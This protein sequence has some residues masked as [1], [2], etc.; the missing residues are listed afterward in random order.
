MQ[1]LGERRMPYALGQPLMMSARRTSALPWVAALS[2]LQNGGGQ[3]SVDNVVGIGS[4]D[5]RW[6]CAAPF[7][8]PA[9]HSEDVFIKFIR[10][11]LGPCRQFFA[12][13]SVQDGLQCHLVAD[14]LIACRLI[15]KANDANMG[16]TT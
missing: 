11:T 8:F 6:I 5:L 10:E 2:L 16:Q 3:S 14:F 1:M 4:N 9:T 15:N 7:P 12:K 13:V